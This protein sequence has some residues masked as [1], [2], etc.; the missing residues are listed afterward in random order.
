ML[1]PDLV[2]FDLDGTLIDSAPDLA[3]AV[4]LMLDRLGREKVSEDQVR[5]W[6]GNGLSM[7]VKRALTGERQPLEDPP[8]LAE[9]LTTFSDFYAENIHVKSTVYSGVVE[10]LRELQNK[11]INLACVTNK[12]ARFS[13][14]L[15]ERTGLAE[16]FDYLGSG[17]DFAQLKPHPLPLVKAAEWF[18]A[19]PA[20]SLMVGDSANDVKAARAAGY[21]VFCVP[22]GY[23][24]GIPVEALNADLVIDSLADL[25]DLLR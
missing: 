7:L 1:T 6:I 5:D 11:G 19:N 4:N 16:Y 10:G 2:V 18:K 9:A 24:N 3:Y 23:L 25:P 8:E 15:M 17:D 22:Y 20:N 13:R 21:K 14:P 12:I